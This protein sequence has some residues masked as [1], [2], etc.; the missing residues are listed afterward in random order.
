M[1]TA[2]TPGL[3]KLALAL[4]L[5][6][7]SISGVPAASAVSVQP[8]ASV[9]SLARADASQ[10]GF[11]AEVLRL[12]NDA[13]SHSRRCG[14][15][16]MKA[17]RQLSWSDVLAAS[18]D[19]HSAD[20]ANNNYFSHYAPSGASPFQRIRA[21]GYSYRAAGEN[22]AAGRSLAEPAAVVNAWLKSAGHCRAIMNGKYRELGVGRV[23]GPGKYGV[24]WTQNFGLRK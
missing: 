18:A 5:G 23:E 8:P 21:A 14:G 19:A 9:V 4:A 22:I 2:L 24:Y 6:C 11:E 20:M 13:R 10:D 17:V 3:R 1:S 12:T 15:K 16:K 7:V